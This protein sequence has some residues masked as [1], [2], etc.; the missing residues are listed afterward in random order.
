M[1]FVPGRSAKKSHRTEEH[2]Q[3]L[4]ALRS[5]GWHFI[6]TIYHRALS[7]FFLKTTS[8]VLHVQSISFQSLKKSTKIKENIPVKPVTKWTISKTLS[9]LTYLCFVLTSTTLKRLV[10][11]VSDGNEPTD[12]TDMNSV[13]VWRFKQPLSQKLGSSMSNLTITF[14]LTETQTS[15][16]GNTNTIQNEFLRLHVWHC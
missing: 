3:T 10:P 12:I 1:A 9:L 4:P 16:T 7:V 2:D 15:I 14:H 8:V 11:Q 5:L 13:W 6:V